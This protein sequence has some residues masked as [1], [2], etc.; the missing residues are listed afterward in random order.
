MIYFETMKGTLVPYTAP[1]TRGG[2]I[3]N[4]TRSIQRV[5]TLKCNDQ[6][7]FS[8]NPSVFRDDPT[9]KIEREFSQRVKSLKYTS[10]DVVNL[11]NLYDEMKKPPTPG[12]S[13]FNGSAV[14]VEVITNAGVNQIHRIEFDLLLPGPLYLDRNKYICINHTVSFLRRL[15]V[16]G[17][18]TVKC[19]QGNVS[20][21]NQITIPT[22][23]EEKHENG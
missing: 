11:W 15:G 17:T 16:T 14:D 13:P 8:T 4:S 6:V 22:K 7:V 23:E 20:Y 5:Y 18:C 9:G 3:V 12:R 21:T 2:C 1:L 10:E 19:V